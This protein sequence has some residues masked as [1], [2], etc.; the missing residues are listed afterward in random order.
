M[1]Q[2]K[3]VE[4][5]E[6]HID[7]HL[8]PIK[9]GDAITEESIATLISNSPYTNYHVNQT[10]IKNAVA[11]LNDILKPLQDDQT[12][13]ELT[14][15][16]IEKI[17]ASIAIKIDADEM[18]ASA[19]ITSAQGGL[20]LSPKAIVL[21]AQEAGV[22]KGFCK[23][24]LI[25]LAK[26]AT[27][28]SPNTIVSLKIAAGETAING[29]DAKILPL[30]ESAQ[31][32]IL[33]PK[34][35]EDGSVN[36]RDLGDIICVKIGDPILKKVPL[37]SGKVGFTV[38][39]TPLTPEPG[40]DI[41]LISGD[42]TAIS[43]NNANVLIS[44]KIGVPK[45][46][47]NGME[48]DEVYKIKNV[49]VASGNITFT[50]SVIIEG[51]V[52]EGMSVVASG[53]VTIGG[54]VESAIVEA[55]GDI[56]ISGGIIGRKYDTEKNAC[57]DVAMSVKINAQGSIFAKYCQYGQITSLKDIRIENQ[58]MHSLIDL[59]GNLVVGTEDN[60]NGTLLGGYIKAGSYISAG[61]V[62][63]T[64][65]SNT[66][67][68]FERK[69]ITFK[70]KLHLVDE[71]IQA[72]NNLSNEVQQSMNKIK[73]APKDEAQPEAL[74][75]LVKT[76]QHHADTLGR[77]LAAKEKVEL[78]MQEYMSSVYIEAT[79]KLYQGVELIVGDYNDRTRR[80]YGPS[81]MT[82]KERKI[83]IEALVHPQ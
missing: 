28:A 49:D 63:A 68:N 8:A 50:G 2:A 47:D 33:R 4:N 23:E 17:D 65:G 18:G 60:A 5:A 36:M 35:Q 41:N 15:Q 40:N 27:D 11:E 10:N 51:D 20:H 61:V 77:L 3:L 52:T 21:A 53:D 78:A 19:E 69:I 82:Y 54:F 56:T 1:T 62:G 6:Q 66:V 26:L 64:A 16:I 43:P 24:D 7:L 32:R 74:A 59:Q 72:E 25:N 38:T 13:R 30:V 76:F 12:G 29:K 48:V 46:I 67:I 42:G 14:Y 44:K 22:K 80:E 37:T 83:H 31:A 58:L 57:N 70:D 81:K 73:T 71:K 34:K 9:G 75:K 55:G 79:E 39:G 45:L